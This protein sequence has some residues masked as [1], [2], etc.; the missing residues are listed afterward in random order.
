MNK[1]FAKLISSK[2]SDKL[3]GF[4]FRVLMALVSKA[5]ANNRIRR[6]KQKSLA[7]EL[8]SSQPKVS[9]SL[10][11]LISFGIIEEK[12]E[13]WPELFFNKQ[14]IYTGGIDGAVE[15]LTDYDD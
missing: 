1:S 2:L 4:D 13:D 6:F 11:R 9:R 5:E 7:D 10:Q 14:Y 8:G 12:G 3:T 15:E